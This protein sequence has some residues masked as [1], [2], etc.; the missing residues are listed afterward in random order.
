MR[1][2][3]VSDQHCRQSQPDHLAALFVLLMGL[4]LALVPIVL[5][6]LLKKY[7]E[8]LALGYVVFRGA[9][10]TAL[11]IGLTIGWLVLIVL[12]LGVREVRSRRCGRFSDPGSAHAGRQ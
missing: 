4:A 1:D 8:V 3:G 6:P 12:S 9:L 11:Y 10:E 5:F 7:N 2:S